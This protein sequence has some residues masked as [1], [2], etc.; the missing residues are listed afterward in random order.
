MSEIMILMGMGESG[1]TTYAKKIAEDRGYE[2]L[3]FD[4]FHPYVS[5][6]GFYKALDSIIKILNENLNKNYVL[7]GY[8]FLLN[9]KY[10]GTNFDY[11]KKSLKHHKIKLVVIFTQEELISERVN[12][13]KRGSP[14]KVNR[15]FVIKVYDEIQKFWDLSN[16]EFIDCSNH[17][18]KKVESYE[19][20]MQIL[21]IT[22]KEVRDFLRRFD[23]KI[24]P[25]ELY[26]R[27]Y[28]SI[29]LPCGHIKYG[30]NYIRVFYEY[31]SWGWMK[32]VIDFKNKRVADIGSN[33]GFFCFKIKEKGAT[34]VMGYDLPKV[35]IETAKEIANLKKS[36]VNFELLNIEKQDIPEEYDII[37]FMNISHHLKDPKTAFKRVFSKAKNVILE[38]H[39]LKDK[40]KWNIVSKE[41]L[42]EI[43]KQYG[44]KLK[45]ETKSRRPN[46]KLML[47]S[48]EN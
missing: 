30:Y 40:P 33:N 48:K 11:L 46:R 12:K 5:E 18:F 22:K 16:A 25:E 19:K 32:K 39:L 35:A 4:S 27:R 45:E 1:K 7:D 10:L 2:F 9:G 28:Q 21:S 42:I 26:D 14:D 36:D 43:A 38:V 29:E 23:N 20:V 6:K 8:A 17:E 24:D 44:H 34:Y 47:F 37:L 31:E 3:S 41:E 15:E 13:V